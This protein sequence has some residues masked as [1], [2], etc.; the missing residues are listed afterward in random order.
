MKKFFLLM[1]LTLIMMSVGAVGIESTNNE[2]TEL[3]QMGE[4]PSIEYVSVMD[5]KIDVGKSDK[6]HFFVHKLQNGKDRN[7]YSLID[8]HK[9][10]IDNKLDPGISQ[11]VAYTLSNLEKCRFALRIDKRVDPGRP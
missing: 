6:F 7:A 10:R 4:T 2:K 9:G 11:D 3:K 8:S 5:L 1:F